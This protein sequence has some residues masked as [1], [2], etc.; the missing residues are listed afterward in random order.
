MSFNE[1]FSMPE[2]QGGQN[3]L[4]PVDGNV[5]C[6]IKEAMG[7]DALLEFTTPEFVAHVQDAYDTLG[8]F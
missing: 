3:S 5:V 8:V 7:G 6:E 2:N 1:A 4:L